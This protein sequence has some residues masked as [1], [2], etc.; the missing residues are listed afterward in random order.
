MTFA[1]G[2]RFVLVD[3]VERWKEA[4]VEAVA[5]ALAAGPRDRP[6]RSSHARRGSSRR[7]RAR[8]AVHAGGGGRG[9]AG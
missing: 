5:A 6:S 2:R 9:G 8:D 7:R 4:D 1:I 3:G